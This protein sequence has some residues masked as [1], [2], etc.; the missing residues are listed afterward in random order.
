MA[1]TRSS[2]TIPPNTTAGGYACDVACTTSGSATCGGSGARRPPP[3]GLQPRPSRTPSPGAPSLGGRCMLLPSTRRAPGRGPRERASP[4]MSWSWTRQ[5]PGPTGQPASE[6][7]PETQET[8]ARWSPGLAAAR[9]CQQ[10]TRDPM[11]APLL[12]YGRLAGHTGMR[13]R[14]ARHRGET[15]RRS[16]RAKPRVAPPRPGAG[17]M[18]HPNMGRAGTP[19]LLAPARPVRGGSAPETCALC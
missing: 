2:A 17:G 19:P 5:S 16:E 8:Q 18:A 9:R 10:S 15:P 1:D 14:I 7:K 12:L 3:T 13:R 4:A 11:A 6:P